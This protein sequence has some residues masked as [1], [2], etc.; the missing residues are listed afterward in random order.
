MKFSSSLVILG[1]VALA[2]CEVFFE[3]K[4]LDGEWNCC[5]VLAGW[6]CKSSDN[7]LCKFPLLSDGLS[8]LRTY[9][10]IQALNNYD[11][12]SKINF[13]STFSSRQTRGRR[14][15]CTRSMRARNSAHSW[16]L[17]ASSTTMRNKTKV[18]SVFINELHHFRKFRR[19]LSNF[20]YLRV[21]STPTHRHVRDCS[22]QC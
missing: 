20:L 17:L 1:A 19:W 13:S 3:E 14:T 7:K 6:T 15:G 9:P 5:W 10:G 4:F 2:S 21:I 22:M 12:Y 16:E 11:N 8:I 18:R